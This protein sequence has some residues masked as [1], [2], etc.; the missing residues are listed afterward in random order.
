L[1][2]L[3]RTTRPENCAEDRIKGTAIIKKKQG[4]EGEKEVLVTMRGM[5]AMGDV[6][7]RVKRLA[8]AG[9]RE[10]DNER[11]VARGEGEIN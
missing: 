9:E 4:L 11:V 7:H 1:E 3:A 10:G 8:G 2:E 5:Q 6:L